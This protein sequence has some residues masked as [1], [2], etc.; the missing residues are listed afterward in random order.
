M[1]NQLSPLGAP[2][3]SAYLL[4]IANSGADI[5]V[6]V[7]CGNDAVNSIK[8]AKQFGL[9]DKM[10]LVVPYMSPFLAQQVGQDLMAGRL[11]RP[12]FL[13]D[14]EDKYPLAKQFVDKFEKKYGYKPEW[15]ADN[16]YMQFALWARCGRDGRHLLSAGGHQGLREGQED[17]VDW[18]ATCTAA[19]PTTSCVR[20]V[21]VVKGKKPTDMKSKDDYYEVVEIVPGEGAHAGAGRV[22]LQARRRHLSS[23]CSDRGVAGGDRAAARRSLV[24]TRVHGRDMINWANFVSQLFNGLVLGALLALISAGLT[25]IYGT[26]GVLNLAH[27]ALFMLGGYAGFVA[28]QAT[29]ALSSSRSSSAR[30]S[31]MLVG[32]VIER[33]DHPPLL[34]PPG[35]GPDP[36]DLRHSASCFVELVRF[37]FGSLSQAGAGAG[38]GR[39]GITSLGFMIYPTYRLARSASSRWRCG[40]LYLLLYRTRLGMVVRAGIED[41][42]DGRHA[43]HQRP[44][45]LHAGVRHRRHGGGLCRHHQRADRF[46]HAR[47]RR[48]HPG[49]SASSWS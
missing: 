11:C 21:I 12:R 1:T 22:R 40:A 24:A 39:P 9:L 37:F 5:L 23:S 27:G 10:K 3:Y 4:N 30:C 41:A 42:G 29:P 14:I 31:C 19:P 44:A 38:A 18:S 8:Q 6:N 17:P 35:G 47:C 20:P 13:V 32:I 45:R 25:I 49:R 28:Y 16:G 36:R 15:G 48:R 43:R 33:V 7:N 26:L 2:D 34:Q 46:A